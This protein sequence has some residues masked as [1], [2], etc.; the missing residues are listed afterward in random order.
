MDAANPQDQDYPVEKKRR[1]SSPQHQTLS[2]TSTLWTST[3]GGQIIMDNSAEV[4]AKMAAIYA[5]RLMSDVQL[6][7]G[8]EVLPAHRLILCASSD[9]FQVTKNT[10]FLFYMKITPDSSKYN[11]PAKSNISLI[12]TSS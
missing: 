7:V 3:D 9:V 6:V 12:P 11:I 2:S 4:V 1:L 10:T 5:E 8:D